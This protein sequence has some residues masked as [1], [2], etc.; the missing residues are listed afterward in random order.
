MRWQ[1]NH[2]WQGNLATPRPLLGHNTKIHLFLLLC[3][4]WIFLG[5]VG[6]APWKPLEATAAA[7]I[8]NLL[9]GQDAWIAP[10]AGGELNIPEPPLYY[11]LASLFSKLLAGILAIHDAARLSN[12]VWMAL[13]LLMVGMT[14]REMWSRG[15]G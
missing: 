6:H 15:A 4:V 7:I 9:L 8:K 5:L 1:I 13:L 11:W 14:G 10:L 2:D 3:A 12:S